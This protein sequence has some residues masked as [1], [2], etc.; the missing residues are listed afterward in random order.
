MAD[1]QIQEIE[2]GFHL[3]ELVAIKIFN[4]IQVTNIVDQQ[5]PSYQQ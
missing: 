1:S 2:A 5:D 4:Q 3:G